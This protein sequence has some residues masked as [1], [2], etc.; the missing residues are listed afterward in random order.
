MGKP[1]K[2]RKYKE[3]NKGHDPVIK[4]EPLLTCLEYFLPRA[5]SRSIDNPGIT[6]ADRVSRPDFST[7]CCIRSG[8]KE[9]R[10]VERTVFRVIAT[11]HEFQLCGPE[12]QLVEW[13]MG[14]DILSV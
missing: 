7:H 3:E 2:Y 10:G 8:Q 1:L 5:F 4:T 9:M 6:P 11:V 12:P 13:R 14:T